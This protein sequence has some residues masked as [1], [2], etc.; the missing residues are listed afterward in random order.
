MLGP[1]AALSLLASPAEAHHTSGASRL[2]PSALNA[3]PLIGRAPT[4]PRWVLGL[5]HDFSRYDQTLKGSDP[6]PGAGGVGVDAHTLRLSAGADLPTGTRL[7]V[8]VP[9]AILQ[10]TGEAPT[11][12][13]GLADLDLQVGQRLESLVPAVPDRLRIWCFVGAVLP[14]GAEEEAPVA[15]ATELGGDPTQIRLTTH[16]MRASLGA[17]AFWLQGG[18]TADLSLTANLGVQASARTRAPLDRAADGTLWGTE[19]EAELIARGGLFD[20]RLQLWAGAGLRHR[21]GDERRDS[22]AQPAEITSDV[23]EARGPD[24]GLDATRLLGGLAWRFGDSLVAMAAVDVP[25]WQTVAGVQLAEAFSTRLG[26][27][28]WLGGD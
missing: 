1:L 22:A 10:R 24:G 7:T 16:E 17:G 21:G 2:G 26:I 3:G 25:V 6:Y 27:Q 9:L 13:W 28:V 18:L 4:G 15:T 5:S 11:T 19:A 23:P 14:T 8:G 12:R 20:Q